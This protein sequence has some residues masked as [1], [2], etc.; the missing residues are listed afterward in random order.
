MG[1]VFAYTRVLIFE[2]HG[3]HPAPPRPVRPIIIL[4]HR[5]VQR[6]SNIRIIITCVKTCVG[7]DLQH[8]QYG[9]DRRQQR[10]GRRTNEG[11]DVTASG[12][13]RWRLD[14][15]GVGGGRVVVN[16][17]HAQLARGRRHG[18]VMTVFFFYVTPPSKTTR[19]GSTGFFRFT[20]NRTRR[21]DG[22]RKKK[23]RNKNADRIPRIPGLARKRPE[24]VRH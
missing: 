4:L 2:K 20:A 5:R 23:K 18:T 6:K 14:H 13:G 1:R 16:R 8:D 22:W 9:K 21:T 15:V 24:D 19:G 17:R 12:P 10:H 3:Y 7:H 11:A